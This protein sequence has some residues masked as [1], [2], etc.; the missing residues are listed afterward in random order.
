MP[1]VLAVIYWKYDSTSRYLKIF[2]NNGTGE[3]YHPVPAFVYDNMMRVTDKTAFVHKYL[4]F[5]LH[6]DRLSIA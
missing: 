3:L 1:Q 5:N 2:Y 4:E 6:F